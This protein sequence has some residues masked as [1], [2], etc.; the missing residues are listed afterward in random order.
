MFDATKHLIKKVWHS[1]MIQIHLN[2]L[3]ND[4]QN[5]VVHGSWK[6]TKYKPTHLTKIG[7]H[8][9]HNQINVWKLTDRLLRREGIEQTYDLH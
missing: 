9:F 7:I 4:N 3:Y 8:Q 6:K 2:Y 5:V 1:L